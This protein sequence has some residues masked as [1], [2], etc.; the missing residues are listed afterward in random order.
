M[1]ETRILIIDDEQAIVE[2]FENYL[3][4]YDYEILTASNGRQGLEIFEREKPDLILVDL[5]MP[6]LGGLQVLEQVGKD[7]PTTPLIV[8]SG[9]GN[10][11]DA[12]DA[13]QKGAWDYLL[14]PVEDL[15]LLR[16]A[17]EKALEKGRLQREN[18]AYRKFLEK[19][20]TDR[21]TEL[22]AANT[23]LVESEARLRQ[24]LDTL[25]VA[26]FIVDIATNSITYHNPSVEKTLGMHDEELRGKKYDEVLQLKRISNTREFV[27]RQPERLT[28][29][30]DGQALTLLRKVSIAEIEGKKSFIE[31]FIDIT[32]QVKA[33]EEQEKLRTQLLH[34]D[35][36]E[37]LGT[38][39][40]GVAHDFNNILSAIIGLS[41]L[42]LMDIEDK[43]G[44]LSKKLQSIK[45]AGERAKELV[46]QIR[47]F[48]R[49]QQQLQIPMNIAPVIKEA[50]KL[51]KSSLPANITIQQ[52]LRTTKPIQG[53]PTQIH[54]IIMNLCTNAYHAM[55]VEGG[56]LRI[57]LTDADMDSASTFSFPNISSGQYLSLEI[58]D[59]GTG[60]PAKTIDKIF[61]PY[62]TTKDR[63]K[64]TGFGLAIVENIVKQHKGHISVHSTLGE[65]TTFTIY[66]P[67]TDLEPARKNEI[68][69][70]LP[71]GEEHIL[72]VDDEEV[73][74]QINTELLQHLGYQ[75]SSSTNSV[76][77]LELIKKEAD[78]FDLVI[79]DYNMPDMNGL[80]L[81]H[82]INSLRT[83]L[84]I[85]ICTGYADKVDLA[86][87]EAIGIKKI[88]FKPLSLAILSDGVRKILDTQIKKA[89]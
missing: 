89:D 73:L 44:A 77:A 37:A 8:V 36:M 49:M 40:G 41:D 31:C 35:K 78:R 66:L 13:I 16:H 56:T 68:G 65:G 26:V 12:V 62:F 20:V 57:S 60:I 55:Q 4:D 39:A 63:T 25:P 33:E 11:S 21:T 72:L 50:I 71:K 1:D 79:S 83:D 59:K 27:S 85:I 6:E 87:A 51:L 88:L 80:Q 46:E 10:I 7:S 53:D 69:T 34:A 48:S 38:L 52:N 70:N 29:Q 15:S 30:K 22:S 5:R 2:S 42:G 3:E 24:I 76:Q 67:V 86:R 23:R 82:Q 32:E 43:K 19:L 81:A 9:T 54:Q 74:I 45:D 61:E 18:T 58:S 47:A 84:P 14:K 28:F 64:G 75:I 17:V